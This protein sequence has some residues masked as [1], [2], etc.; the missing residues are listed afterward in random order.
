MHPMS[1]AHV[2]VHIKVL[3]QRQELSQVWVYYLNNFFLMLFL[4]DSDQLP[5][6]D[7]HY[8]EHFLVMYS[9]STLHIQNF[10]IFLL[11]SFNDDKN[12]YC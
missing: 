12:F 11:R 4:C 10:I 8:A 3:Q 5:V 6:T 9:K 2:E 1:I 7:K